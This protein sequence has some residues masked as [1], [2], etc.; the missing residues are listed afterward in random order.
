MRAGRLLI[1]FIHLPDAS[2]RPSCEPSGE[3]VGMIALRLYDAED[4]TLANILPPIDPTSSDAERRAEVSSLFIYPEHRGHRLGELAI[5]EV[6]R[7]AKEMGVQVVTMNAMAL[8][9][10]IARYGRM[11]YREYKEREMRYPLDLLLA[12][13]WT[14]KEEGLAAFLEK[15]LT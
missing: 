2:G 4:L 8:G 6:E 7:I 5:Y 3:A 10:Q 1:W 12:C 9:Y 11:G 13:G 14:K 15:R